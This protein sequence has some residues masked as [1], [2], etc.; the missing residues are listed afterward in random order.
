MPACPKAPSAADL[1]NLLMTREMSALWLEALQPPSLDR[2][3][4][5]IDGLGSAIRCWLY[6]SSHDGLLSY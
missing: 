2:Y 4:E 1:L 6:L 3:N 5:V